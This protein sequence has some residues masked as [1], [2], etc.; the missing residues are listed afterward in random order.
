[1]NKIY[2]LLLFAAPIFNTACAQYFTV[3]DS[4]AQPRINHQSQ[5]LNNG[6]VITFGGENGNFSDTGN[7]YASAEIYNNGIW[8][9]TGS[10][11]NERTQFAS[12]VL[13][14]GKVLAIGGIANASNN[15]WATCEIYD[16][17]TSHWTYTGA[18]PNPTYAE[19]AVVLNNGKVLE[20]D[21]DSSYVYDPSTGVWGSDATMAV[22]HGTNPSLTL[23]QNGK[24]LAV[25]GYDCLTCADVY[26]PT[27]NTWTA[28]ANQCSYSRVQTTSI[29]LN[30]GNV[31]VFGSASLDSGQTTAELYNPTTNR[32]TV[33]GALLSNISSCP[34]VLLDNGNPLVWGFG[35]IFYTGDSSEVVQIYNATTGTW[36]SPASTGIGTSNNELVKMSNNQVLVVAGGAGGTAVPY[37][38]LINGNLTGINDVMPIS[39]FVISPNPGTDYFSFSAARQQDVST[40]RI[41]DM[42]GKMIQEIK[43]NWATP[44]NTTALPAGSYIVALYDINNQPIGVQKWVKQ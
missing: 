37:C 11:N 31:L 28:T 4:L 26:D 23:L 44:I 2:F 32:F 9:P 38:W 39:S 20:A 43:Q 42:Q 41:Y 18:L 24:V 15:E 34:A 7:T 36:F 13:P 12:V 19:G 8:T 10:M 1:M 25:G 3:T 21:G 29:L 16:P 40:L 30:N 27:S 35:N 17:A 33:T 22:G 6:T 14:N 5:K